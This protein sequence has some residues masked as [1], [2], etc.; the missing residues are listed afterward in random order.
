MNGRIRACSRTASRPR[1]APYRLRVHQ[2]PGP[3]RDRAGR[4]RRRPAVLGGAARRAP[5][6]RWSAWRPRA[7]GSAPPSCSGPNTAI[8]SQ[9]LRG[10]TELTGYVDQASG[11][12]GA[13]DVLHRADLPVAGHLRPGRRGRRGR[14]EASTGEAGS[15]LDRLHPNGRALVERLKEVGDLTLVLDECHHLLEVWGRLLQE[16]LDEL[17]DAFV[18]GLTATPPDTLTG[19]QKVLVDEL[20][21]DSV[22]SVSIPAVVREGDLAPF[23]ELAWLTT[24]TPTEN[25]WLAAQG[26]RFAEL[27]TAL[28]DP[29][30]GSTGVLRL[31][32]R[33]VRRRRHRPTPRCGWCTPG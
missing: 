4:G 28:S 29:A 11:T 3:R 14:S 18:L 8:Q 30:Y 2:A 16:V 22:F 33:E 24:P 13:R 23:A 17:P 19:D 6:R 5:A 21:G 7:A 26:E 25:D 10:W 12:R 31:A 32:G 27:T 20:F 1:A 15:L 9:W